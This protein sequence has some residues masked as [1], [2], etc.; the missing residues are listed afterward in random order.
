MPFVEVCSPAGAVSKEQRSLIAER[1]VPAVMEAE[2]VPDTEAVRSLSWLV[3]HEPALWSI[4]G[5]TVK[6][7]DAP[8]FMVRVGIPAA[9]LNDEKRAEIV[10]RVTQVLADADDN[11]ERFYGA[12]PATFIEINEIPE[13]NLGSAGMVFRFHDIVSY[14]LKGAPGLMTKEEVSEALSLAKEKTAE[15]ATASS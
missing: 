15:P 5:K 8:F 7:D 3:W 2:G 6:A 1:L 10:K 11:P 13:G 9:S 12:P 14:A 4:G